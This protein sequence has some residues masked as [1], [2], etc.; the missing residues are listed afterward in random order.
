LILFRAL[1]L[2]L[3]VFGATSAFADTNDVYE[4]GL[5]NRALSS[6]GLRREPN[7]VGKRIERIYIANY[8]VVGEADVWPQWFNNFHVTTT[9]DVIE[10]EL[11]FKVGDRWDL[12][13]VDESGRNLRNYLYLTTARIIPAQGSSGGVVAVVVTKDIWS[14]RPEMSYSFVGST[15]ELL[16]AHPAEY[17]LAGRNKILGADF[18]LDLATYLAGI[19]YA[20]PRV[21]GS[22]ISLNQNAD[23][24]WNKTSGSI[25]GGLFHTDFGQPLY[26]LSTEWSWR[27]A[28]D[29]RKDVFRLFSNAQL[30]ELQGVGTDVIPYEF[31]RRVEQPSIQLT[32]SYGLSF[33]HDLT[34]GWRGLI[35]H[36]EVPTPP[37]PVS[38]ATITE[39]QQNI[40]PFTEEAGI[41]FLTYH[42]YN[43]DFIQL[44]NIETYELTEDYHTG[45]DV[46]LGLSLA[47]PVFGFTSDFFSPSITA[48]YLWL[49]GKDLFTIGASGSARRQ[50]DVLPG[51]LWVNQIANL[52]VSNISPPFWG[53]YRVHVAGRYTRRQNDLDHNVDAIGGDGALRGYP[54]QFFIGPNSFGGNIE[55]R[56]KPYPWHSLAFGWVAFVDTG[57]AFGSPALME[58]HSSVGA[59]LRVGVPQFNRP[60]LRFDVATPLET[61]QGASPAYFTA[62]FGQA[63]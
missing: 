28:F 63:F 9:P 57:D 33:K 46:T 19:R 38:P 61:I 62:Q 24:I 60:V 20:D 3:L 47:K 43:P 16:E 30:V 48:S 32:R 49:I 14:L 41:V 1:A 40:L 42:A 36:Y 34:A 59:G 56:S 8:D 27:V 35:K 55:L 39:F 22:R 23:L 10:R 44:M 52:S 50:E 5:I 53:G 15:L 7:P 17:N 26:S 25:E 13:T 51:A 54:S 31:N 18:R 2:T 11:L 58:A 45:P 29:Y 21:F 6:Q 37:T 12:S 4:E